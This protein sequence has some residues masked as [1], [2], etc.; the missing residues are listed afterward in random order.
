VYNDLGTA[1]DFRMFKES[2]AS[3][4][5]AEINVLLDSG[6]QGV[7]EFLTNAII[8]IKE[9][10]NHKLTDDEKA[11]NTILAK[12][13]VAIEHINRELKIF[14]FARKLTEI[15]ATAD[16]SELLLLLLFITIN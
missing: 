5:P 16:Y 8:P 10:K 4:L 6:Y 9:T 1:H 7:H 12:V 3:V 2:L 13:R 15:K 11:H 14:S